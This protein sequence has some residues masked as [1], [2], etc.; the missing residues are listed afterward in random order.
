MKSLFIDRYDAGRRLVK[1]LSQYKNADAVVLALPHGGV[2]VGQEVAAGLGIPLDIVITQKIGHP[3]NRRVAICAVAEDG[4]RICS[5]Y[6]FCGL[7]EDWIENETILATEEAIKKRRK[8][9]LQLP[10]SIKG[11]TVIVVDEGV[12]TGL[13]IKAALLTIKAQKPNKIVLAVPVCPH[14]VVRELEGQVDN[15][16]VLACS[17]RH[18]DSVDD[19]YVFFPEVS[20]REVIANL[21]NKSSAHQPILIPQHT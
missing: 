9:G 1:K 19:Y 15:L 6:G 7:D 12:T 8:F 2:L 11:K 20:D 17:Y 4:R 14:E 21:K 10:I 13:S 18:H 16:I 3:L 5:G